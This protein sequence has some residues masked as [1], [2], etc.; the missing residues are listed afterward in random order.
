[1]LVSNEAGGILENATPNGKLIRTNKKPA[2]GQ[3]KYLFLLKESFMN[4]LAL[5]NYES[6]KLG[7][8]SIE[9]LENNRIQALKS[10]ALLLLREVEQIEHTNLINGK[11]LT[12]KE[13]TLMDDVQNYEAELI[14]SALLQSKGHQARAARILGIKNNTLNA[15]IKRYGI[16]SSNLLGK[17][18]D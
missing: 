7:E 3:K 17:I 16:E 18:G 12:N 14:R 5:S 8:V 13:V 11:C 4:G 10:L 2:S 6:P 15:K 1:M 9:N